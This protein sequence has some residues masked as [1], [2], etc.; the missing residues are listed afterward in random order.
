VIFLRNSA[1]CPD[2]FDD[3]SGDR[4]ITP[5]AIQTYA[6]VI[7]DHASPFSSEKQSMCAP[8]SSPTTGHDGHLA[9]Q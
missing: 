9:V 7:D 2:L 4:R 3:L 6:G 8:Y 5:L 1:R